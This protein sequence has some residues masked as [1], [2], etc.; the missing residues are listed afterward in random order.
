[1]LIKKTYQGTLPDNKIVNTYS[2]S[3]TD[4]YSCNYINDCNTYSTSEIKT[5]KTWIDG[6]PIYRKVIEY[7]STGIDALNQQINIQVNHDIL[8]LEECIS[9][10]GHLTSNAGDLILPLMEGTS[11]VKNAAFVSTVDSSSITLSIINNTFGE[12]RNWYFI[13]EY[14]KTTD[15]ATIS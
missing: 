8:N 6:K 9:C 7:T 4:T 13:L 3:Q 15:Q 1:M 11:N 2:T 12:N 10:I 5:D 14:T